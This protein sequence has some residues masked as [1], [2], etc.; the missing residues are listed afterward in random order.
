M[1]ISDTVLPTACHRCEISSKG[2]VPRERNDA[3]MGPAELSH[4]EG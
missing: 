1:G 2:T 4:A 3:E